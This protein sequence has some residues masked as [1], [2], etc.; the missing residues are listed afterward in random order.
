MTN[1][2]VVYG[3]TTLSVPA[4]TS[5]DSVKESMTQIFPEL[6]N[7]EAVLEGSTIK[8]KV[9][10]GTKGMSNLTV[11]YGDTR[12]SVP[13]GSSLDAV[14]ESMSQIFPELK[15][16]EAKLVGSEVHFAVKAGTKGSGLTV[17][18]GDTRL[19]VEAGT[20]LDDI[21]NSMSQIFPELKNS[22][23][24]LVGAE[25][26]FTVKAGTK[27]SGLTV[28]Y[29][30][31]RL[32]VEAGTSLDD[33]KNSMSQ[34]FPELKNSEAKLVGSEVHFT[35]KAGT[36][37]SGL[38]VVYGDTR[39]A[40]EAGTS[41]EDI[42]NSMATIFPELKTAEAKLVGSE[43][44]FAVKAG[45]KG[46]GLTVVYGDTRLAV[47]EGTNLEDIKNSMSQIF[48]ELK[49]AE[50]KLVG[51]EIHFAVKAGTKGSGL[52]V[53]YGDTR[54]AV[55]AGTSLEDIKNSM[56]TIFPELKTAEA[57]LVGNEVHFAVKAGTKGVK[58]AK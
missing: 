43:V 18:Y 58:L 8:F 26:H 27:G 21:K 16:A 23:A 31:T 19:A 29:G 37:G 25:V 2:T 6:K 51:N 13:A 34:I 45:T 38:T 15:S 47:E 44:H 50:A 53:V 48:P 40:V 32:A 49:S 46:A 57:K 7:A 33:I 1:L 9:K 17:V 4:G 3:D 56:A 41:L 22:E 5:L 20:S 30:D 11:V 36:K 39:L 35:V 12:L 28:V 54:L 42:K 55:E 24:K 10:A 52:T 14:K